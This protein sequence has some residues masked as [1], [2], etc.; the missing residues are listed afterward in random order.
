MTYIGYPT[1]AESVSFSG[2][3]CC[4][5]GAIVE[6]EGLKVLEDCQMDY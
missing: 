3:N 4:H 6:D 2:E 5:M 1:V